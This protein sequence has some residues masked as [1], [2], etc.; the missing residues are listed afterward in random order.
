MEKKNYM[1]EV[2]T[3]LGVELGE[4]FKI[5]CDGEVKDGTYMIDNDSTC[6]YGGIDEDT[7]KSF[8]YTD[9]YILNYLLN[10]TY[11]IIKIPFRPRCGDL[12]WSFHYQDG[13]CEPYSYSW[14]GCDF[15]YMSYYLGLCFRTKEEAE[16]NKD[17]LKKII[18]YY[19]GEED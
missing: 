18:N 16:A 3:L 8:W 19:N 17:K 9:R 14:D 2:A 6:I 1:K 7:G 11:Q 4:E 15:D 10:G 12:Y 13:Y 5:I